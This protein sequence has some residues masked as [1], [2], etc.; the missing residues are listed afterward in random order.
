MKFWKLIF[1]I[2]PMNVF[3][4]TMDECEVGKSVYHDDWIDRKVEIIARDY[5]DST[6]KIKFKSGKTKWVKPDDLMTG[7][8][9]VFEDLGEALLI[10]GATRIAK[11]ITE[12]REERREVQSLVQREVGLSVCN[13]SSYPKLYVAIGRSQSSSLTT[14]GWYTIESDSCKK[15]ISSS[16]QYR[17]Y[18]IHVQGEKSTDHL[19]GDDVSLCVHPNEKFTINNAT[20]GSCSYPNKRN[21]FTQIDT[22]EKARNF[23]FTIN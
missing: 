3:A 9:K 13:S 1:F 6:V 14:N 4:L 19:L 21:H 2:L 7:F 15:V 22:G 5:S 16:L 17:Y 8:E 12:G 10:E 20:S 18:Y 11:G 23:K